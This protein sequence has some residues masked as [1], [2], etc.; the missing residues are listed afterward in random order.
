M[1]AINK[2]LGLLAICAGA[3]TLVACGGD[4]AT[5]PLTLRGVAAT[6]LAIDGNRQRLA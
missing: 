1:K 6:G 2:K 4:S 5:V 3:L